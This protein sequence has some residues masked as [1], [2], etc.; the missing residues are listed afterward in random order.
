MSQLSGRR[1]ARGWPHL[2]AHLRSGREG[3]REGHPA[4][5]RCPPT[6]PYS[7]PSR[8]PPPTHR[9]HDARAPPPPR[10]PSRSDSDTAEGRAPRNRSRASDFESSPAAPKRLCCLLCALSC[11]PRPPPAPPRSRSPSGHRPP[12]T[13]PHPASP[14]ALPGRR[15][16]SARAAAPPSDGTRRCALRGQPPRADDPTPQASE[17][18]LSPFAPTPNKGALASARRPAAVRP[19]G[20]E[21]GIWGPGLTG[22]GTSDRIVP[23]PPRCSRG[24]GSGVAAGRAA[25]RGPLS[26]SAAPL[27][28]PPPHSQKVEAQGPPRPLEAL[29]ADPPGRR[30]RGAQL[31]GSQARLPGLGTLASPPREGVTGG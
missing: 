21:S 22:G 20:V 18:N 19:G 2:G 6:A 31:E 17:D 12:A 14:R 27:T 29:P 3:G 1:G 25:V 5:W 16:P 10:P 26:P 23:V 15:D 4:S 13:A 11:L 7:C 9:A 8:D 30:A 24:L 28:P